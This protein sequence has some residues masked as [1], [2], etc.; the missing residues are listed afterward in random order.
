MTSSAMTCKK[1]YIENIICVVIFK[2]LP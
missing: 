2:R 1:I